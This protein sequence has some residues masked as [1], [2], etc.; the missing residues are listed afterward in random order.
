M[1]TRRPWNGRR[2]VP[3]LAIAVAIIAA[4]LHAEDDIV[5]D[6]SQRE[7][8]QARHG[9]R[10]ELAQQMNGMFFAPTGQRENAVQRC[11][12]RLLLTVS[13]LDAV[14]GLSEGQR[15]RCETAARLDVARAMD[16]IDVVRRRWTG[17]TIDLQDPA[18][19]Q[20]W[21][22]FLKE[23]QSVQSK[24]QDAGGD[25]S[26]LTRVTTGVLDESQRSAW[27]RET[28]L[29]MRYQWESVIDAGM[30]QVDTAMGLSSEQ[31]AAI[32]EMLVDKPLRINPARLRLHGN[33][34]A[35]FVCKYALSRLDQQ[36]LRSLVS[37]RQQ[38]T[39][40]QFIDQG[41]GMAT[42]L[43]QQQMILE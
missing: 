18:G 16:A 30:E 9:Q 33:H 31:H 34:F 17:R 40:Q 3:P 21:Q 15:L 24:L 25:S 28:E 13:G 23:A 19:Q 43:K 38:K 26:L 41:R 12:D 11:L 2:V 1:T 10:V 42:H 27:Q 14:C 6:A 29:R 32:R 8:E 39:L 37:Q 20:E 5:V 7:N 4:G 22:R 35:P 36:K